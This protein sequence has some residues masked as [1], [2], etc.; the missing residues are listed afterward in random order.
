M[1]ELVNEDT[2]NPSSNKNDKFMN[3]ELFDLLK[4]H[5]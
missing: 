5:P 3:H 4:G 2:D 1:M